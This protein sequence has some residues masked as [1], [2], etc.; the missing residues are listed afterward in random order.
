ME[1]LFKHIDEIIKSAPPLTI[2]INGNGK[3]PPLKLDDD[4]RKDHRIELR[5]I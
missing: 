1:K 2:D 3:L 5:R 4:E